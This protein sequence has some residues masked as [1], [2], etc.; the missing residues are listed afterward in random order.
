MAS[1]LKSRYDKSFNR[2]IRQEAPKLRFGAASAAVLMVKTTAQGMF[3]KNKIKR[4]D[5]FLKGGGR[6]VN[7]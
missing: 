7:A 6:T 2:D 5:N 3:Y 1:A 4:A